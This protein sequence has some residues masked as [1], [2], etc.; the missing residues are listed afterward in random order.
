MRIHKKLVVMLFLF[1]VISGFLTWVG[2]FLY[3]GEMVRGNKIH[4]IGSFV[5]IASATVGRVFTLLWL[6]EGNSDLDYYD[7]LEITPIPL[8]FLAIF[9]A[10]GMFVNLFY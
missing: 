1:A 2:V 7:G 4:L 9:S 6:S 8:V 5:S 10:M 3:Y